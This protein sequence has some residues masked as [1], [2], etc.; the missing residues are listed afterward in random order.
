[1]IFLIIF[2]KILFETRDQKQLYYFDQ[3][4]LM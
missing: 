4:Q 3:M 2:Y 1:M